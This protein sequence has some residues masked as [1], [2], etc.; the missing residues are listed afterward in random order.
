[1]ISFGGEDELPELSLALS[2]VGATG[3]IGETPG[4]GP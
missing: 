4:A 3:S 2:D 1:L